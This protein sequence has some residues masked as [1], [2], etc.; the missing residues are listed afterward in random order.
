MPVRTG[1]TTDKNQLLCVCE[2]T[3]VADLQMID[4]CVEAADSQEESTQVQ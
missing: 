4:G 3:G 2:C 1:A